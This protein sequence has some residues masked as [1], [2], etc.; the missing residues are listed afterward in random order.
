M[1]QNKAYKFP[2]LV[3]SRLRKAALHAF[4]DFE[5]DPKSLTKVAQSVFVVDSK[6][7][8]EVVVTVKTKGRTREFR[9]WV[10]EVL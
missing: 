2:K 5:G 6:E 3:K 1:K 4:A 8:S 10:R 7:S 9:V